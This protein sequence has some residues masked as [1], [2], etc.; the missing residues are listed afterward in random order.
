VEMPEN[1]RDKYQYFTQ[2]KI[3]KLRNQGYK[4]DLFSLEEAVGD[5]VSNYLI[6]DLKLGN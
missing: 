5:Y 1:L 4:H 3:E 2:A 6:P